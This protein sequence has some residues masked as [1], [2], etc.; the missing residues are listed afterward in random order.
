VA[1]QAVMAFLVLGDVLGLAPVEGTP[2]LSSLIAIYLLSITGALLALA[3]TPGAGDFAKGIRRA[4][5][6]GLAHPGA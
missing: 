1:F 2:S 3:C 6:L 5:K 4:R